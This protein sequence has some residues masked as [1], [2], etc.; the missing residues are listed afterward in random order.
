MRD[1]IYL[2]NYQHSLTLL[3][4]VHTYVVI[5]FWDRMWVFL[6]RANL[7]SF[8]L[9]FIFYVLP[10]EIQLS[11]G[12]DWAPIILSV[13]SRHICVPVPNKDLNFQRHISVS[14]LCSVKMR[15]N[16]SFRWYYWN[17]WPSQFKLSFLKVISVESLNSETVDHNKLPQ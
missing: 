6:V 12:E 16:Y 17:W 8:S 3:L 13:L 11:I 15:G 5:H 14:F 9:S 4:Y 10:L 1:G 7:C 2:V